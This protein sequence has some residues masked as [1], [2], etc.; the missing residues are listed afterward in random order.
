M[1]DLSE[2]S[3]AL[4]EKNEFTETQHKAADVDSDG[5]VTLSDLARLCQY[6]SKKIE[7]F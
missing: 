1:T 7:A 2:L 4:V 3:I 6:V 5:A